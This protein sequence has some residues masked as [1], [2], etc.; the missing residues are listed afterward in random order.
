ME[1]S[2]ENSSLQYLAHTVVV[3]NRTKK[4]TAAV[5][6]ENFVE[7]H[8]PQSRVWC[9]VLGSRV[10]LVRVFHGLLQGIYRPRTRKTESEAAAFEEWVTRAP[11]MMIEQPGRLLLA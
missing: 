9:L 3:F 8:L 2:V 4:K 5:S 10:V 11:G 7:S 6:I 1:Y